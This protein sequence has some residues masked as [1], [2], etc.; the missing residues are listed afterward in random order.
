M[1]VTPETG[2]IPALSIRQPWAELIVS[3]RKTIELRKWTRDYRGPMWVH[4]ATHEDK[5]L[6]EHFGLSGLFRGGY[7]GIVTVDAI[8]PMFPERWNLWQSL[9]LDLGQYAPGWYAWV[10]SRPVRFREP[11]AAPGT[12]KLFF[13]KPETEIRLREAILHEAV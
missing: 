4:A 8:T 13:P 1:Y 3:G 6:D 2:K 5:K 9:H 11:V 10:L 7:I 12:L